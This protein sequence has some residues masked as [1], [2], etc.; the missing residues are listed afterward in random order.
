M[1]EVNKSKDLS[2]EEQSRR[3]KKL[4]AMLEEIDKQHY[5]ATT[6]AV[7]QLMAIR[8]VWSDLDINWLEFIKKIKKN[9][10]NK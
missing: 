1:N 2:E 5:D 3:N 7:A 4:L 9:S 8:E 10:E 6:T